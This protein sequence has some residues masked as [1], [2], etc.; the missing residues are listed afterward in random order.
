MD[1]EEMRRRADA[2]QDVIGP[3]HDTAGIPIGRPYRPEDLKPLGASPAH[4][5]D[6]LANEPPP[7]D[8]GLGGCL[9]TLLVL[10][11]VPTIVIMG[12]I[13]GG[14]LF[15]SHHTDDGPGYTPQEQASACAES[16]TRKELAQDP[17]YGYQNS[18]GDLYDNAEEADRLASDYDC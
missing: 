6:D 15:Y 14:R 2:V 11:A 1:Q 17:I 16:A 4:R 9:L 8:P 18:L 3:A 7:K 13:Y 10:L 5:V 12:A